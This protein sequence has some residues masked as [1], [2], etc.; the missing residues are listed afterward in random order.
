MRSNTFFLYYEKNIL[1]FHYAFIYLML[2]YVY[3]SLN[4]YILNHCF[5][6]IIKSVRTKTRTEIK[7]P[8][9]YNI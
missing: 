6:I 2:Y 9:R 7:K 8:E 5:I 3:K 1:N 4:V